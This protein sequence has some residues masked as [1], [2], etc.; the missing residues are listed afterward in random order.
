[1]NKQIRESDPQGSISH[2]HSPRWGGV[3]QGAPR[4]PN[5]ALQQRPIR[6]TA[7]DLDP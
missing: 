6:G 7:F 4:D 1:M 5:P 3:R 2:I